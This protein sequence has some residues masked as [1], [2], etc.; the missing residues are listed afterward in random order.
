MPYA[1]DQHVINELELLLQ[2]TDQFTYTVELR[3]YNRKDGSVAQ[4]L[5]TPPHI[6]FDPEAFLAVAADPQLYGKLLTHTLFAP[7][8]I[9][10]ALGIAR[11]YAKGQG[12]ALRLR[13]RLDT[14]D[15]WLHS[16]R[17]EL[18]LDPQCGT[19]L[20]TA[21]DV[22]FSR[23]VHSNRLPR[24]AF[25]G[26]HALKAFV[27]IA[28]PSDAA[29]FQFTPADGN[30]FA[31]DII[32]ALTTIQTEVV[33]RATGGAPLTLSNLASGLRGCPDILFLVCHGRVVESAPWIWLEN[34]EGESSRVNG[35]DFVATLAQIPSVPRLI[36]LGSCESMGT[37]HSSDVLLSLGVLLAQAGVPAVIAFQ[38]NL[39][40]DSSIS[41]FTTFFAEL[42]RDGCIDRALAAARRAIVVQDPYSAPVLLLQAPDSVLWHL[43]HRSQVTPRRP[44]IGM[45]L[46]RD[47]EIDYCTQ[48][49]KT[50]RSLTIAGAPGIGK[51]SIAAALATTSHSLDDIWWYEVA[52]Q[53]PIEAA[54]W[55]LATF[56]NWRGDSFLQELLEE[57]VQRKVTLFFDSELAE[58]VAQLLAGSNIVVWIDDAH[59]AD[60]DLQFQMFMEMLQALALS[61][62]TTL[63]ITRRDPPPTATS[64]VILDG[65]KPDGLRE[66][67]AAREVPFPS[68]Q[69]DLLAQCTGGNPYLIGLV[70]DL[71]QSGEPAEQLLSNLAHQEQIAAYLSRQITYQLSSDEVAVMQT[72]AVLGEPGGSASEVEAIA[73]LPT[74]FETLERLWRRRLIVPIY[75][76]NER[77]FRQYTLLRD[78]FYTRMSAGQRRV[79]HR[80]A[81]MLTGDQRDFLAAGR[82]SEAA[83]EIANAIDTVTASAE[84]IMGGG[85]ASELLAF[86]QRISSIAPDTG[87]EGAL[88]LAIG[89]TMAFLGETPNAEKYLTRAFTLLELLASQNDLRTLAVRACCALSRLHEGEHLPMALQWLRHGE[90]ILQE[91]DPLQT[92]RLK[93]RISSI[94]IAEG[95]FATALVELDWALPRIP[96]HADSLRADMLLHRGVALCAQGELEAGRLAFDLA[97]IIFRRLADQGGIAATLQNIGYLQDIQGDREAAQATYAQAL[98]Y[99]DGVG[100]TERRAELLL[101]LGV[102]AMNSG[103]DARAFETF[104]AS[105][106][107][108]NRFG[109]R[110]QQRHAYASL[111]ELH[112]RRGELDAAA[113]SLAVAEQF[114][115]RHEALGP[116]AELFRLQAA[117]ALAQGD[118]HNA[119]KQIQQAIM[120]ANQMGDPR[121][122]GISQRVLGQA[123]ALQGRPEEASAV[124]AK[125]LALLEDQDTYEAEQTRLAQGEVNSQFKVAVE[126]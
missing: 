123:L 7:Q 59:L 11:A 124:F 2:R 4:L 106:A 85:Q 70:I 10:E 20:G 107:L 41:L 80:R 118:V 56:L 13:L 38:G 24:L 18:L 1:R 25:R 90:G 65:L 67:L 113:Q 63:L 34:A 29:Q 8:E 53:G 45:C 39:S 73:E 89:E 57:A 115:A 125:S 33:G 26:R 52:G 62:E 44:N 95:D 49:L 15:A 91:F 69:I 50:T 87:R 116:W 47:R 3:H 96:L 58:Q 27:A 88:L 55:Q 92:L 54:L 23:A 76:D 66:L 61:R 74:A 68:K 77:R 97:I 17:W 19:F 101:N 35:A 102:L 75:E 99:A 14:S 108:T 5:H 84:L 82:H 31:A 43:R 36:V 105:I 22:L 30:R 117:L 72:L 81:A 42:R 120:L 114:A 12:T 100:Q 9:R 93:L 79:L 60:G 119:M 112:L 78:Y 104:E 103:D 122:E 121:E 98:L 110:E 64:T 21:E 28:A 51:S 111:A 94:L 32:A 109:Y 71:V 6:T 86:L 126:K 48:L 37:I 83:E 40:A 46:G 16:L